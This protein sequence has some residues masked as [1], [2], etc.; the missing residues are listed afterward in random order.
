MGD[1]T[2]YEIS[3]NELSGIYQFAIK[4]GKDSGA[5]LLDNLLKRRRDA[6]HAQDDAAVPEELIME[7][8]LNAVDIVTKTDNGRL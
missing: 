5:I 8:K 2:Q 7:E 3:D 4:L 6:A 1:N